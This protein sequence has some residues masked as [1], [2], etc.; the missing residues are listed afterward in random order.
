MPLSDRDIRRIVR[1]VDSVKGVDVVRLVEGASPW[2]RLLDP[3]MLRLSRA[4]AE[5]G[6]FHVLYGFRPLP[7]YGVPYI[8]RDRVFAA[9]SDSADLRKV[10]EELSRLGF[11]VLSRSDEGFRLLDLER[12]VVIDLV[13]RPGSLSWDERMIERCLERSGVK[14]LSAE[15]YA[16]SLLSRGAGVM[17]LELAG[18]VIYANLDRL[19]RGY[20]MARASQA[21]VEEAVRGIVEKLEA[22]SR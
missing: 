17:A 2:F 22:A 13:S 21:S 14:V 16:V 20:L 11:R 9:R 8:G 6:V 15:D 19:D 10:F 1:E 4:L 12:Y 7:F 3:P 18:K 5:L